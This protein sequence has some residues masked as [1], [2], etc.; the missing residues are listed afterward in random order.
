MRILILILSF[1]L[2]YS[3]SALGDEAVIPADKAVIQFDTKLGVVT[4]N[5]QMHSD[6]SF[7]E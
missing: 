3:G 7:A 5:H 2:G 1:M 4:F 6:L